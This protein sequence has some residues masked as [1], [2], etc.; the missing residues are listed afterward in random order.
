MLRRRNPLQPLM[1]PTIVIIGL[2]FLVVF[3]V[4]PSEARQVKKVVDD[5]YSLEQEAKFSSSWE[6]FHSS[7]Q[8]H[9]SRDRYISDRPH[10][11]M[12]HFGVDTF[13]FE[14]SRP[15]KL[16]N[17]K[18]NEDSEKMEAYEVVVT[19]TYRGTYGHFQFIQYVY[20]ANE[21]GDWRLLW[22]YKEK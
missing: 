12:N 6:L 9:F 7:M 19:K 21:E 14:M 4:I 16:K 18:L 8:S 17:W 13:E 20:V 5:F 1:L 11:F 15:K 3:F 10:T 2:F 22:D